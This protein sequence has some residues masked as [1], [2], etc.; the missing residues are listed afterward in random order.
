MDINPQLDDKALT[1]LTSHKYVSGS[2][3]FLDDI[4]YKHYVSLATIIPKVYILQS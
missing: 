2:R 1:R 3:S 4:L